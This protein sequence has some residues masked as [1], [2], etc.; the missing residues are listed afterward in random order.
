MIRIRFTFIVFQEGQPEEIVQTITTFDSVEEMANQMAGLAA[1]YSCVF[2]HP[3]IQQIPR[4]TKIISGVR[5]PKGFQ[6]GTVIVVKQV[7]DLGIEVPPPELQQ[8]PDLLYHAAMAR[9]HAQRDRT[10][11]R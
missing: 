4:P 8:N 11:V 2:T 6:T 5:T 10:D 3:V 9:A 7:E 1:H